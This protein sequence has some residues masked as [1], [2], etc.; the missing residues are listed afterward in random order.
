MSQ[1]KRVGSALIGLLLI[2]GAAHVQGAMLPFDLNQMDTSLMGKPVPLIS[3]HMRVPLAVPSFGH[4]TTTQ[5]HVPDLLPVSEQ[6]YQ[7]RHWGYWLGYNRWNGYSFLLTGQNPW[8]RYW[9]N[10][11]TSVGVARTTQVPEPTSLVL[12]GLGGAW[13]AARMRRRR[14]AVK[15]R[16]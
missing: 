14:C 10:T 9:G 13:V 7:D 2:L 1:Q 3:D 16:R 11:S 8:G 6:M 12:F 15:V 4:A 5:E